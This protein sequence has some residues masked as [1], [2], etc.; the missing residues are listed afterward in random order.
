MK[1]Q[2]IVLTFLIMMG[3]V[4][5]GSSQIP[6]N[7]FLDHTDDV[8]SLIDYAIVGDDVVFVTRNYRQSRTQ[9]KVIKGDGELI[10]LL[11]TP[12][13]FNVD[14]EIFITED[15][16]R[17]LL[18]DLSNGAS[19]NFSTDIVDIR[20]KT[21]EAFVTRI[22]S[23]WIGS[24]ETVQSAVIDSLGD[25]FSITSLGRFQIFTDTVLVEE[26]MIESIGEL[27]SNSNGAIY[28]I[29][30][31]NNVI[32]S[33][34]QLV[35]TRVLEFEND[36]LDVRK[37]DDENLI[38]F[39]D[40][41]FIYNRDFTVLQD[42]IAFTEP[43][44]S[45]GQVERRDGNVYVLRQRIDGFDIVKI[46][47]EQVQETIFSSTE[48]QGSIDGFRFVTDNVFVATGN[49]AIDRISDNLLFRKYSLVETLE[50]DRLGVELAD[51]SFTY[52]KDT[53]ISGAPD[54][55]LY[56]VKYS[57]NNET[58]TELNRLDVYSS[59]YIPHLGNAKIFRGHFTDIIPINAEV[60][61]ETTE[62]VPFT[63]P[64][65]LW[66][67]IPG[68]NYMINDADQFPFL[69]NLF[70]SVYDLVDSNTLDIYPNPVLDRLQIDFSADL[71]DLSIYNEVGRLVYYSNHS[72]ISEIETSVFSS[73][74]YFVILRSEEGV[75][76][77]KFLK[78]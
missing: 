56:E 54:L 57:F 40:S 42:F 16:V 18:F 66:V 6:S 14:A 73:G 46:D 60:A 53:I 27:Y 20:Y 10:E 39:A 38:L 13:N 15:G 41:I 77:G 50:V 31:D 8:T 70:T 17:I 22:E 59:G 30:Y 2:Q 19:D 33:V 24:L 7:E 29:D 32:S 78:E 47:N 43:I 58:G 45:L 55:F 64:D 5:W 62:I 76:R 61:V 67:A 4:T 48:S 26:V 68:V 21:G 71:R 37:Y 69:V 1:R 63:H 9:V 44:A 11:D 25:I 12:L 65:T 28:M 49:Y 34:D 35:L 36:I 52:I 3:F 23:E 74:L 75:F 72:R 51:F